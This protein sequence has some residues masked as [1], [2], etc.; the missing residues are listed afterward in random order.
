VRDAVHV[1]I[2]HEDRRA[3]LSD[4]QIAELLKPRGYTVARRTVAKYRQMLGILPANL[5][6]R[7]LSLVE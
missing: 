2:A 4:T 5:R 6:G 3:P 1:I 7:E